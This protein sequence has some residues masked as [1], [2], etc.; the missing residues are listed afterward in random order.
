MP[1][2]FE[3]GSEAAKEH[4]RK[5]REGRKK[6]ESTQNETQSIG[7]NVEPVKI[8]Q[9]E[10]PKRGKLIKDSIE[11]KQYMAEIRSKKKQS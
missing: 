9:S 1:K 3:K 4:M 8:D 2:N 11:A 10:K 6:K 5:V 7:N